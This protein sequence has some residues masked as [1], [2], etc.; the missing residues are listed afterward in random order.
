M[1]SIL[2][3]GDEVINLPEAPRATEIEAH[4][5]PMAFP[6]MAPYCRRGGGE[7]WG[8]GEFAPRKFF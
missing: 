5:P 6:S 8:S 7:G 2:H 4:R 1:P 3:D